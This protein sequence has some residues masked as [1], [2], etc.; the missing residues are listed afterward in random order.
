MANIS[1][2]SRTQYETAS[3][4]ILAVGTVTSPHPNLIRDRIRMIN[5]RRE[6]AD[7]CAGEMQR[8]KDKGTTLRSLIGKG[9][10]SKR[11]DTTRNSGFIG[12]DTEHRVPLEKS[13]HAHASTTLTAPQAPVK[14]KWSIKSSKATTEDK[15]QS[16]SRPA[17]DSLYSKAS[18]FQ[19]RT[20][21]RIMHHR[22]VLRVAEAVEERKMSSESKITKREGEDEERTLR[23]NELR[24][25]TLE[26]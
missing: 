11:P 3:D 20:L 2:I 19:S 14:A 5:Q 4:V 23:M 13:S 12:I 25:K 16:Q 1:Q 26:R 9:R 21:E 18:D 22:E 17:A 7:L 8:E 6:V 10:A 24:K 15:M